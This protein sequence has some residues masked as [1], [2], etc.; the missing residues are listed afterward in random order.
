MLGFGKTFR[1]R[2]RGRESIGLPLHGVA[3]LLDGLI[4]ILSGFFGGSFLIAAADGEHQQKAHAEN[5]KLAEG[6]RHHEIDRKSGV[7][8]KSVSVR[9]DLGGRRLIKKK[10][11]TK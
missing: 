1:R 10:K 7:E 2:S 5:R 6:S 8:G 4:D 3:G 11:K 9:V